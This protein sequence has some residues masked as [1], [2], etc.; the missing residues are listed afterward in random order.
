MS[1]SRVP[2]STGMSVALS[3]D[4]DHVVLTFSLPAGGPMNVAI[5]ARNLGEAVAHMVGVSGQL[6]ER[7]AAPLERSGPVNADPIPVVSLGVARGRSDVEALLAVRTGPMTLA[8]SLDLATLMGMCRDL[9][10]ATE[11]ASPAP[12]SH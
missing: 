6:A 8:F 1:E 7:H 9:Q 2:V 3:E 4:G 12:T 10:K 5:P 11:R